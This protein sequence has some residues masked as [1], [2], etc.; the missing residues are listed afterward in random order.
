[1][2]GGDLYHDNRPSKNTELKS[3][4]I[5]RKYTFG[6][7]PLK[8]K[9]MSSNFTTNFNDKNFSVSYPIFAIHGNHDDRAGAKRVSALDVLHSAGLINLFGS[10]DN[11]SLNVNIEPLII[12]KGSTKVGL[13]GLGSVRDERLY[14]QF[15]SGN[16]IFFLFSINLFKDFHSDSLLPRYCNL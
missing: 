3:I 2:H 6:K 9:F 5:L 4:E 16:V 12:E 14:H 10:N 15:E 8:F 13:Y 11:V 7:K 1:M